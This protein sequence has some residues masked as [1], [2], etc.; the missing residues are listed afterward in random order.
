M[1]KYWSV[2]RE[3][4]YFIIYSEIILIAEIKVLH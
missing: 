2:D 4:C 1:N 3:L